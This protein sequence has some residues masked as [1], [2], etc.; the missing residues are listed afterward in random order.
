[1]ADDDDDVDLTVIDDV[2][3]D[4]SPHD[5]DADTK[6]ALEAEN[7]RLGEGNISRL[8]PAVPSSSSSSS[9]SGLKLPDQVRC[10]RKLSRRR[11]KL[12]ESL[13]DLVEVVAVPH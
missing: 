9:G 3:S 8:Y 12:L 6:A 10:T 13:E 2:E 7:L 1:M 4:D 5:D 11:Q